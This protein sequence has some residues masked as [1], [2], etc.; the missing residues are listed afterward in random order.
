MRKLALI[1]FLAVALAQLYV[2]LNMIRYMESIL[3]T[4]T[5]F[6]FKVAPIDPND[7]VRGK[8][9][10]LGFDISEYYTAKSANSSYGA[11]IFVALREDSLGFAAVDTILWE[12]PPSGLPYVTATSGSYW[13]RLGLLSIQFPFTRFY[14]EESKAPEAE[15]RIRELRSDSTNTYAL[16][17]VK[18]GD[19][20]IQ[21][22]YV[23]GVPLSEF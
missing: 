11:P 3:H 22:V 4:G 23:D 15:L 1:I 9:I 5:P 6:K 17:Y 20:V 14:M 2:P 12:E 7:P 21:N 16:I 13:E 18:D 10:Q 8:Y 19:A